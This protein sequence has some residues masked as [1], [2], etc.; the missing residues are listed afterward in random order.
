MAEIL[1]ITWESDSAPVPVLRL[2]G[3]LNADG[4]VQLRETVRTFLQQA[5]KPGLVVDL[6][7]LEFVASTGLA[8]FLLLTE[9]FV[10]TKGTIVFANAIPAVMQVMSLLNIDQ[11]LTLATSEE[12]ALGMIGT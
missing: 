10:E 2:K 11:F 6:A 5:D 1:S 8:T 4:S 9:E 3:R 7:G 12:V